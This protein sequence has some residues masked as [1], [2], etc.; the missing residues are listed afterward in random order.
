[1]TN[2]L[3]Y[4]LTQWQIKRGH[5]ACSFPKIVK[6]MYEHTPFG[7]ENVQMPVLIIIFLEAWGVSLHYT[8]FN[9]V[10]VL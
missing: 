8:D 5:P 3:L 6:I 4:Y 7:K 9:G 2:R 1:M 10:H